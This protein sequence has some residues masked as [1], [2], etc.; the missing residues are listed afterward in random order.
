MLY[1]AND[2]TNEGIDSLGVSW[3]QRRG[4]M[5]CNSGQGGPVRRQSI[6]ELPSRE[7]KE[8]NLV[9]RLAV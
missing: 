8:P 3:S 6:L 4:Q 2:S 9:A 1:K 7:L 5:G